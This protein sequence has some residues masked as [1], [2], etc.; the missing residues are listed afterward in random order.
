MLNQEFTPTQQKIVKKICKHQLASLYRLFE[1]RGHNEQDLV[2]VLIENEL[3]EED[4]KSELINRIMTFETLQDD[5]QQLSKLKE[6][7]LSMFR[8]L[9]AQLEDRYKD[10]YPKAIA[11]LWG[12][13]FLLEELLNQGVENKNWN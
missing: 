3:S 4:Y 13:L 5:P 8:H 9:L 1:D 12:N 10:R 6:E 2:L 11:N 7:D